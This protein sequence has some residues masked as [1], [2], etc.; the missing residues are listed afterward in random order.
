[1]TG[2]RSGTITALLGWQLVLSPLL[3]RA[4][5]LGSSRR[6]LLDGVVQFLNPGPRS[7]APTVAMSV[8]I[9]IVVLALWLLVIPSLGAW[10]MRTRDA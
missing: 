3:L 4:S 1:M 9:A 2:S 5:S 8:G 7:G 6:A 10:R